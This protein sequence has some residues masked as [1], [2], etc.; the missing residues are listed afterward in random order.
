MKIVLISTSTYPS[1]QGLR[2]ISSCLKRE[3]YDVKMVFMPMAEDYSLEYSSA[4]LHQ[5]KE[6]CNDA[7]LIGVSAYASTSVRAEQ[8]INYLKQ[9]N[10]PIV[11]GGPHATISS[12]MCIK[13]CD[14]VCRGEGED[15]MLE[16]AKRVKE[17]RHYSDVPN[18]WIKK[19][20][21]IIKNDIQ[22][23]PDCLDCFA[24]P[25]YDLE[26]HY[27]L[28]GSK[29]VPF[30]EKHLNGMIFFMT[31]RGCPNA[32]AYC[33]NFL[34]RQLYH[35]HG[36]LLRGYTI[37][38]VIKEL[39]RLR[40]KFPSVGVF[41]IRDETFFARPLSDIK[42]FAERY[43]KEVG[44]RWKC[45]ADPTTM[46]EEK[47][48]LLVDAGLTDIIIG[49]Q[50]GSDRVNFEVYKRFIKREQVLRA[51]KI[52]NKFKGRLAVMYDMITTN[53]YENP[54]DVLDSIKILMEIPKPYFLSVNNLV[55]FLGTPLY[56][57]AIADG[58]IKSKKDSA[59]H[60]NYWDRWNHIKLKK[61]NAYLNLILNLMR[62]PVTEKRYGII[63]APLLKKLISKKAV[64]Y[65]L[66]HTIPTYTAGQF[67]QAG[68]YFREHVAKPLYRNI[69]PTSV[70]VWY[71]KVRYRV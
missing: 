51:V 56:E 61:K 34:Y 8:L 57:K 64:D 4:V 1:D 66:K 62:G 20:E 40:D 6:I 46:S 12:D 30:R 39:R 15:A 43:Q 14:I 29:L 2:T 54:E 48:Q 50:S 10:V 42:E 47:L 60:L 16:L 36:K 59:S 37:D 31:T 55:F 38:Y 44:V 13:Q 33:S 21:E 18:L 41:D 24:P 68:D 7:K 69:L 53:P 63:P 5:L 27:L 9:L 35:G 49:I 45:L 52:A 32:C 71:D 3:R 23:M 22:N 19:G 17:G 28:E 65:N 26:D 67:V 70:K 11:W 58:I 25:D